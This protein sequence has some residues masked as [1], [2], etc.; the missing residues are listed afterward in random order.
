MIYSMYIRVGWYTVCILGWDDIQY[1]LLCI[2]TVA[3][4]QLKNVLAIVAAE[5][6]G[7][8]LCTILKYE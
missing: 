2:Q 8:L 3:V 7:T 6:D 1:C 5:E 4:A